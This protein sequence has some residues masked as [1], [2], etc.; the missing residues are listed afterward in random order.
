MT[1]GWRWPLAA[2]GFLLWYVLVVVETVENVREYR[3]NRKK[4]REQC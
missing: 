3:R 2:F 4:W 1:E